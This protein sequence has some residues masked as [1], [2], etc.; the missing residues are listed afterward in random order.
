[1]AKEIID[2][3]KIDKKIKSR[4]P[5]IIFDKIKIYYGKPYEID[6]ESANGKITIIQPKIGEILDFGYDRFYSSVGLL[7]GNTTTYRKFLWDYGMNWNEMSD[8][9]LFRIMYQTFDEEVSKMVF[10]GLNLKEFVVCEKTLGEEKS[11]ILYNEN[12]DIEINE[13]VYFHMSQYLRNVFQVFPEEKITSSKMLQEWYIKKDTKEQEA[14]SKKDS[15]SMI[16]AFQ[17]TLSACVNHPGF[18]YKLRELDDVGV[19]EFYD[20]VKRL[21]IYESSTAMLKGMFSGF[22]DASGIKPEEYNFMRE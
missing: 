16:N 19:A 20:S 17:A 22:V 1:M 11:I 5:E 4:N 18:K 8:F 14:E 6:L 12:S 13:E 7:I 9:E 3:K 15:R 21:Q 2:G 10:D